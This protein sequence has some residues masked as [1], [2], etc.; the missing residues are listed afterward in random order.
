MA[1]A[2]KSMLLSLVLVL[3]MASSAQAGPPHHRGH[4]SRPSHY[5]HHGR[6]HAP[7]HHG[8]DHWGGVAAAMV[9]G[10]L[11]GAA[12]A[13]SPP[14]PP[15]PVVIVPPRPVYPGVWYYCAS[16]GTYYPQVG[17]CPEGWTIIQQ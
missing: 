13:S 7:R 9:F 10:G 3:G 2:L 6:Y 1:N 17:Y 15:A 14:P 11:V 12:I 5:G 8:H 16:A 4:F